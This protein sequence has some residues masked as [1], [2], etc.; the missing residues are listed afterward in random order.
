[1]KKNFGLFIIFLLLINVY[2]KYKI[3][4]SFHSELLKPDCKNN[5]KALVLTKINRLLKKTNLN[6]IKITKDH[7]GNYKVIKKS[8]SYLKRNSLPPSYINNKVPENKKDCN[9]KCPISNNKYSSNDCP[10]AHGKTFDHIT[11][12]KKKVK[13]PVYALSKETLVKTLLVPKKMKPCKEDPPPRKPKDD[14]EERKNH[15]LVM[16]LKMKIILFQTQ[17]QIRIQI[18][19]LRKNQGRING[20]YLKNVRKT[21][22]DQ[23][24]KN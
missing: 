5:S 7:K 17:T 8:N 6:R 9:K 12:T 11:C 10:C 3:T 20:Y 15:V 24:N 23:S 13:P 1:M 4:L 22:Q 2:C 14:K 19:F 18:Q 16:S 21:N